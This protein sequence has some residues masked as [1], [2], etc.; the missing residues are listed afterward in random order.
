MDSG[1][2]VTSDAALAEVLEEE[3]SCSS[4]QCERR[5]MDA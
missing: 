1:L 4:R 2:E 5:A 3:T